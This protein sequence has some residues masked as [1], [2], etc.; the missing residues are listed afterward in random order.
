MD[1]ELTIVT[2]FTS[3]EFSIFIG[4]PRLNGSNPNYI[5]YFI[6]DDIAMVG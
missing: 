5:Y 6:A 1:D 2:L 4:K 3:F